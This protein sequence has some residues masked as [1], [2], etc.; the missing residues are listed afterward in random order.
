MN[1]AQYALRDARCA[2]QP[3][4]AAPPACLPP[5]QQVARVFHADLEILDAL[6]P[7]GLAFGAW[8]RRLRRALVGEGEEAA[9][10]PRRHLAPVVPERRVVDLVDARVPRDQVL[11]DDRLP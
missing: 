5:Q 9:E 1:N 2:V 8:R 4:V 7:R 3:V 6:L 11:E 10:L